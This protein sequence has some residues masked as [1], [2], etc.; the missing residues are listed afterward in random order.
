MLKQVMGLI[1]R[2]NE[3]PKTAQIEGNNSNLTQS[4]IQFLLN[5]LRECN[6]KGNQVVDLYNTV[7]KLQQQYKD[8]DK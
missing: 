4:E 5:T 3:K 2:I 8:L 7:L 1:N 6:F